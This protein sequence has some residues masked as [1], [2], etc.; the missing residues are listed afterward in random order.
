[1]VAGE[2]VVLREIAMKKQ[3]RLRGRAATRPERMEEV[4]ERR[5]REEAEARRDHGPWWWKRLRRV[6]RKERGERE[7]MERERMENEL[8]SRVEE[9]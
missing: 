9:T 5:G 1:M 8:R 6:G 7:R 3:N 4:W 2:F